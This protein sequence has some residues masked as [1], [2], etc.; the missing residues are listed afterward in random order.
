M[1]QEILTIEK[2]FGLSENPFKDNLDERFYYTTRQHEKA[3]ASML[4][5]ITNKQAIGL[6]VGESGTGKSLMSYKVFSFLKDKSEYTSGLVL[7]NPHMPKTSLLK[8]IINELG[9]ELPSRNLSTQALIDLISNEIIRQ[10]KEDKRIVLIIDEAHFLSSEALH[11]I[12]TLTNLETPQEKLISSILIAESRFLN[13]LGYKTYDSLRSRI[14]TKT[15]LTPLTENET[16]GYI[17]HRLRVAGREN[18]LFENDTFPIIFK[19]SKGNCRQI[20]KI[21]GQCLFEACFDGKP[22]INGDV[23]NEALANLEGLI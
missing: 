16:E 8:E 7:V 19:R 2:F 3:F 13:R 23:L 22:V 6:I 12:R 20:N 10:Y 17:L 4:Y 5:C 11:M 9:V 15:H 18:E 21:A 1:A 14:K